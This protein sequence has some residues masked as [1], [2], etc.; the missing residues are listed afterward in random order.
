MSC[1][2]SKGLRAARAELEGDDLAVVDRAGHRRWGIETK[3]FHELTQADHLEHGHHPEPTSR[4]AQRLILRRLVQAP[5]ADPSRHAAK[6]FLKFTQGRER[7]HLPKLL[8]ILFR[9]GL[10]WW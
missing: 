3:I 6:L 9:A 2:T 1:W 4:L 7:T 5:A 10:A 8:S